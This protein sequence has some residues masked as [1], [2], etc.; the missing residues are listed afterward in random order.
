MPRS[1][2]RPRS[3]G[4]A[5]GRVYYGRA[6]TG[7]GIGATQYV[8]QPVSAGHAPDQVRGVGGG[9]PGRGDEQWAHRRSAHDRHRVGH[10]TEPGLGHPDY[11]DAERGVRMRAQAA[12]AARIP[13]GID[14]QQAQSADLVQ[15]RAQRRELPPLP[16]AEP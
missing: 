8:G 1:A 16:Y 14:H 15:D 3:A 6:Y 5:V 7:G 4:L 11:R 13:V 12:P 2:R 9:H 10:R